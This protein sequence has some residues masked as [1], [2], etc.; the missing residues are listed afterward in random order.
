MIKEFMEKYGHNFVFVNPSNESDWLEMRRSG[1]GGSDAGSIMGMNKYGSALTVYLDKKGYGTFTGNAAT[2][3]GKIMEPVIRQYAMQDLGIVIEELPYS[4]TSVNGISKANLDGICYAT[5]PCEVDGTIFQ[6]FAGH[7]IKT[8]RSGSDFGDK[9]VPESHYC[10]V[11]HYMAVTGLERFIL[12][13]YII[14]TDVV[15]H[16]YI[17]RNDI[18]IEQMLQAEVDFWEKFI[19]KDI[20]PSASGLDSEADMVNS[21]YKGLPVTINLGDTGLNICEERKN[22]DDQ[23]KFWK[24][25]KDR[26]TTELKKM[27]ASSSLPTSDN[28]GSAVA[29][30]FSLSYTKYFKCTADSDA[31]KRDGLF[32][33]YS[34]QSEVGTLR[35]TAPKVAK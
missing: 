20:M 18:F 1:V 29:G 24:K 23:E 16:Y 30:G 28:K 27:M 4:L 33:Q 25:E 12:S 26:C 2:R 14:D 11:Q 6:G 34:K 13:V 15:K 5:N 31:L 21:M 22:A 19:Q 9:E 10:Q 35:V 3:R 17:A 7:E 32:E 8:S